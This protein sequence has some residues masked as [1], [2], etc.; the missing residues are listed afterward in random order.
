[1][2]NVRELNVFLVRPPLDYIAA[3][4]NIKPRYSL[5]FGCASGL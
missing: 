5:G 4:I 3:H 1:M 2:E